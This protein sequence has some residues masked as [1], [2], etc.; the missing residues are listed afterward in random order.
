MLVNINWDEWMEIEFEVALDS[1]SIVHMCAEEDALGCLL[2]V[3]AGSKRGQTFIVGHGG[4]MAHLGEMELNL[5]DPKYGTSFSSTF[6]IVKVTQPLMSVG[7]IC[8]EGYKV[9]F[10]RH[11]A[12]ITSEADVK[13]I[14][15][16]YRQENGVYTAKLRL[17][18]PFAWRG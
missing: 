15:R 5:V 18:S 2:Q 14:C 3:S 16:L 8:D 12:I 7:N 10:D 11:I 1:G 9:V 17:T 13:E 6:Q 4:V